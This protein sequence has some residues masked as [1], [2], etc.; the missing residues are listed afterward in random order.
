MRRWM[1]LLA[2]V[3]CT[4]T[5]CSSAVAG[6]AR[7]DL[8]LGVTQ[9]TEIGGGLEVT[10][11]VLLDPAPYYSQGDHD[12]LEEG[13]RLVALRLQVT[14][15]AKEDQL[16]GPTGTVHFHGSDGTVY[17]NH[18]F[19]ETTAGTMFDQLRL[20]PGQTIVGYLTAQLP[21]DVAVE[22]VDFQ[23]MDFEGD[24]TL[25]WKTSGQSVNT[26]PP[27]P[28]RSSDEATV[29]RLGEEAEVTG[30]SN[31]VD[32]ALRVTATRIIDP[33]EPTQE[34]RAGDGR[35]LVGVE[36]TVANT[37]DNAYDDIDSD[38]DLRIFAVH[39]AADEFVRDH[40]HGTTEKNGMPLAA[41]A[42]D[43]WT[44]LFDVPADFQIDRISYSPSF[45]DNSATVWSA[46]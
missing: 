22:A 27:L 8:V 33:A 42:D 23:M 43:T 15:R 40:I 19:D 14:N 26:A 20:A 18:S 17:D 31:G 10:P 29:H 21:E 34:V 5:A 9:R 1:S 12:K 28:E 24:E 32:I 44:V 11:L 41:G 25:L 36:F 45:G 3:L 35:R 16:I 30:E 6:T 46:N 2:V 13:K 4:V 38:A 7:P 39:N 37:G